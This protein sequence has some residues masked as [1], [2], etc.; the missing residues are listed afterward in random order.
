M[1]R[2]TPHSRAR[3]KIP[4]RLP[5]PRLHRIDSVRDVI[6][7][8]LHVRYIRRCLLRLRKCTHVMCSLIEIT[9]TVNHLNTWL[10]IPHKVSLIGRHESNGTEHVN[11][12]FLGHLMLRRY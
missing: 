4:V 6:Q 3:H 2:S 9:H 12:L 8:L 11:A 7:T 5:R 10:G 1:L